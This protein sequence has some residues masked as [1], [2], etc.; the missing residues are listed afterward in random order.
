M[1]VSVET[2]TTVAAQ[3][4]ILPLVNGARVLAADVALEI[5][6]HCTGFVL[7]S[8]REGEYV[9]WHVDRAAGEDAFTAFWGNYFTSYNDA[10]IDYNKRRG[11]FIPQGAG[12]LDPV[13]EVTPE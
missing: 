5:D 4:T 7:A 8:T 9:T 13:A 3:A 6:Q 11:A 1:T 12:T 2:E 10:R